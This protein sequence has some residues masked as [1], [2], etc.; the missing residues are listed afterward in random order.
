MFSC[1]VGAFALPHL[2]LGSIDS[3]AQIILV[4]TL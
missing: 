4:I 1:R 3:I 2:L